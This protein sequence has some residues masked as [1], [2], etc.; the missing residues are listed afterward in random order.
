MYISM[1]LWAFTSTLLYI[2]YYLSIIILMSVVMVQILAP[3]HV[4]TLMEACECKNGHLLDTDG[5]T[6]NDKHK[7]VYHYDY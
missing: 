3:K 5:F 6:C 7:H 1:R 2:R 4:Q